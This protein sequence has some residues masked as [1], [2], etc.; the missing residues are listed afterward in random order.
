MIVLCVDVVMG[1]PRTGVGISAS[2]S[3]TA[4]THWM[5]STI[6]SSLE[7]YGRFADSVE[8]GAFGTFGTGE[9]RRFA[10]YS[11][12]VTGAE[13][14]FAPA[15]RFYMPYAGFGLAYGFQRYELVMPDDHMLAAY[16]TIAPLRFDLKP[17][18]GY[19]ARI[20]PTVSLLQIRYGPVYGDGEPPQWFNLGSWLIGLDLVRVGVVFGL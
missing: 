3:Y 16:V 11:S 17:L 9:S 8:V 18:F 20:S 2:Y 4:T 10:T 5:R 6:P 1:A 14:R 15:R 13:V 12:I 7:V 19:D